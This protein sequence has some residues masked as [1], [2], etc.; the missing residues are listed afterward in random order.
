V[1]RTVGQRHAHVDDREAGD[2]AIAERFLDA[3]VHGR[4]VL[5][6]D[7]AADD[8]VDEL[9]ALAFL[10][11][12]ETDPDVAVLAAAAGPWAWRRPSRPGSTP[13][14]SSAPT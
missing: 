7:H 10:E 1:V 5:A 2:H 3:L 9:V 6:R 12:L 13:R 11:R 14:S 8:L 4:D